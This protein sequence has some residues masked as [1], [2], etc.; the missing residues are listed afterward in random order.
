MQISVQQSP[1]I[2][3][4][5]ADTGVKTHIQRCK[6]EQVLTRGK[7]QFGAQVSYLWWGVVA[8]Q[9]SLVFIIKTLNWKV[10]FKNNQMWSLEVEIAHATANNDWSGGFLQ[11]FQGWCS[12]IKNNLSNLND[13]LQFLCTL[14][15]ECALGACLWWIVQQGLRCLRLVWSGGHILKPLWARSWCLIWS[16]ILFA[17]APVPRSCS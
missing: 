16:I 10:A 12:K 14:W 3:S 17:C 9:H 6:W 15:A 8:Q 2:A 11:C 4:H 7:W 5:R 13:W 1:D